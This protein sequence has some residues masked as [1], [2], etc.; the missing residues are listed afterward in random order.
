MFNML[1]SLLIAVSLLFSPVASGFP[2]KIWL[3]RNIDSQLANIYLRSTTEQLPANVLITYGSCQANSPSDAHY[4]VYQ[5][6]GKVLDR[7]VWHVP[8]QSNQE[9]VFQLGAL[10]TAF[11]AEVT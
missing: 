4:L 10:T 8:N 11:W 7:L 3:N 2:L 1:I 9:D 5:F 6:G